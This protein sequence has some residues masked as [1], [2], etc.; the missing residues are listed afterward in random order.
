VTG[1]DAEIA[2]VQYIIDGRQ[3]MTVLKDVRTLVSDAIAAAVAFLEGE[4]PPAT[5]TYDNGA[6]EVPA[7]PSEVITVDQSNVQ[8]AIIDS[9]YWDASEFTGLDG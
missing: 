5:T 4:T 1:Q 3:S 9:G 6:Y 7:Q 2:S 8:E